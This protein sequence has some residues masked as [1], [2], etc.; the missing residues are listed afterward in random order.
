M[1]YGLAGKPLSDK[2]VRL[3]AEVDEEVKRARSAIQAARLDGDAER[4][5]DLSRSQH[6]AWL[7]SPLW[8]HALLPMR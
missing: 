5:L 7:N 6:L 3:S 8:L 2:A 4:L 1:L